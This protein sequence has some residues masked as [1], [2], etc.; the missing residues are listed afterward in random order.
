M[1]MLADSSLV[2]NY[3][4]RELKSSIPSSVTKFAGSCKYLCLKF[5]CIGVNF[6]LSISI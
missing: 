5:P 2:S 4:T 6:V 3:M 1:M